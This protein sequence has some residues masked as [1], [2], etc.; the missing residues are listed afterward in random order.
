ME[1][2]LAYSFHLGSDKNKS[3]VAKKSDLNV[4]IKDFEDSAF[5]VNRENRSLKIQLKEKD[6]VIQELKREISSKDKIIGKL[7]AEK[8]KIKEQL[9]EFKGFWYRIIKHF[10]IKIGFDRDIHFKEVAK[11]LFKNGIWGKYENDIVN[12]VARKVRTKDEVKK[13]DDR[14]F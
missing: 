7:R 5:E 8:E 4:V 9:Q 11:E 6:N 10:Q 3:K 14:R 12:D 2:E 13:K 1:Q